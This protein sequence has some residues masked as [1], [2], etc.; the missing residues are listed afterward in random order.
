MVRSILKKQ[1][2]CKKLIYDILN[3]VISL[4]LIVIITWLFVKESRNAIPS[5]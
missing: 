1:D 3:N 4:M 5:W 2:T